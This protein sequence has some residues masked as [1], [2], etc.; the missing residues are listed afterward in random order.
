MYQFFDITDDFIRISHLLASQLLM[1]MKIK[2]VDFARSA[3]LLTTEKRY[4][5]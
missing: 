2:G 4:L 1:K 3:L 5:L